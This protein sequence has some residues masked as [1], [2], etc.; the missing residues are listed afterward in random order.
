MYTLSA[1]LFFMCTHFVCCALGHFMPKHILILDESETHVHIYVQCRCAHVSRHIQ[2]M[3]HTFPINITVQTPNGGFCA[4]EWCFLRC[5][6]SEI[7]V[8]SFRFVLFLVRFLF[9]R[10]SI[11]LSF[12]WPLKYQNRIFFGRAWFK[13][14]IRYTVRILLHALLQQLRSFT[15]ST[16]AHWFWRRIFIV[17]F[18]FVI[19]PLHIWKSAQWLCQRALLLNM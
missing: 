9:V 4:I 19:W 2:Y 17:S 10:I 7:A 5:C 16:Y 12:I 8:Y 14:F 18:H 15:F 11:L 13:R 6:S 3:Y 1:G